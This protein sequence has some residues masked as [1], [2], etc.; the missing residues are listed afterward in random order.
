M[1]PTEF[2]EQSIVLGAP[3]PNPTGIPIKGLP[4]F[5][6]QTECI[7]RWKLTWKER[8]IALWSGV[9]WVRVMS[10]GTQPPIGFWWG[11]DFFGQPRETMPKRWRY[12]WKQPVR[13]DMTVFKKHKLFVPQ[14]PHISCRV[15]EKGEFFGHVLTAYEGCIYHFRE[16][17]EADEVAHD[18]DW[19]PFRHSI[20]CSVE[21]AQEWIDRDND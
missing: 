19:V 16:D 17:S 21:D 6:T 7:S 9:L 1:L 18:Q 15:A 4:V 3:E 8:L 13:V 14:Y 20:W 10:K 11:A 2:K 5:R 12:W